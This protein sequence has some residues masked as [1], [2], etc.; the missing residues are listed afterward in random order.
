MLDFELAK[1]CWEYLDWIFY[2]ME[3]II[4][5]VIQ[6]TT[7]WK[8]I[9]TEIGISRAELKWCKGFYLLE[10]IKISSLSHSLCLFE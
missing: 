6:V 1:K 2:K 9:A 8:T 5:E 7:N 10:I 3:N 4:Q